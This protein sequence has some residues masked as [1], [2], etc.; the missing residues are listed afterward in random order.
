MSA[1][2]GTEPFYS[3]GLRFSCRRCS[4]CCKDKPGVVYLSQEDLGRL[5]SWAE[6]SE[7]QFRLAYCRWIEQED[8]S[9][10]LSLRELSN[11]DCVFW[12]DGGGCEA[13]EARPVQCRTY[14]FWTGV[15]AGQDSWER[16]GRE[17]PGIGSGELHGA[18]DIT[19]ALAAYQARAVIRKG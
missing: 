8:G 6:L 3:G 15:L 9:F 5:A 10:L 11:Y 19:A 2:G 4:H 16:E 12:K 14:P 18:E 13:Y 7:E 17:C 1:A